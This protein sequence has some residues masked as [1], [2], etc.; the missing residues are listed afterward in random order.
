MTLPKSTLPMAILFKDLKDRVRRLMGLSVLS[1]ELLPEAATEDEQET[2]I[3]EDEKKAAEDLVQSKTAFLRGLL[4][5]LGLLQYVDAFLNY[6]MDNEVMVQEYLTQENLVDMK[7]NPT[8]GAAILRHVFPKGEQRWESP[9]SRVET[10]RTCSV[11]PVTGLIYPSEIFP[12][13]SSFKDPLA[14]GRFSN[15]Y[16]ARHQLS[17]VA[18]KLFKGKEAVT[19]LEQEYNILAQLSDPHVPRLMGYIDCIEVVDE[20]RYGYYALVTEYAE[21]GSLFRVLHEEKEEKQ[22]DWVKALGI[23][24]CVA[25]GL[26]Y[27]HSKYIVHANVNSHNVLVRHDW[28]AMLTDF[29]SARR[30]ASSADV[31]AYVRLDSTRQMTPEL[32]QERFVVLAYLDIESFGVVLQ[33]ILTQKVPFYEMT[34]TDM[35]AR[36]QPQETPTIPE[37]VCPGGYV[38]LMKACWNRDPCQVPSWATIIEDLTAIYQR[39]QQPH[40]MYE[41]FPLPL[42]TSV[43]KSMVVKGSEPIPTEDLMETEQCKRKFLESVLGPLDLLKHTDAFMAAGRNTIPKLGGMNDKH[44]AEMKIPQEDCQVIRNALWPDSIFAY[45]YLEGL[46]RA[47]VLQEVTV[48]PRGIL[49]IS[50]LGDLPPTDLE[51]GKISDICIA[52]NELGEGTSSSVYHA[53]Y[54]GARVVLKTYKCL[55]VNDMIGEKELCREIKVLSKLSHPN[56]VKLIGFIHRREACHLVLEC[57]TR[58][59]LAHLL[60]GESKRDWNKYLSIALC[61]AKGGKYMH[62]QGIVHRDLKAS[63]ILIREDWSA[64]ITDFGT[65]IE[66]ASDVWTSPCKLEGGVGSIRW[67]APEVYAGKK[68]VVYLLDIYSFGMILCE[69]ATRK[70]PFSHLS[71]N[72]LLRFKKTLGDEE[73]ELVIPED[74]YPDG[75]VSLIKACVA[76]D[77]S[78][79]PSWEE[80]IQ[81][82]EQ[83]RGQGALQGALPLEPP[84]TSKGYRWVDPKCK[85]VLV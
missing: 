12:K 52:A 42:H 73:K 27:M 24:L 83:M 78:Q 64:C 26:A 15:V 23:A 76:V 14:V 39:V 72:A 85:Y 66:V 65:C 79:R 6:G 81:R 41:I 31:L 40:W 56:I 63:N 53:K 48:V 62:S 2:E 61:V 58:N 84:K 49:R 60:A 47:T 68:G 8:H 22:L 37:S 32:W 19:A 5:P 70:M 43:P 35:D 30:V 69:I 25:K 21:R 57:A 28:S 13:I 9:P 1:T 34:D 45:T 36:G 77:P 4:G 50:T 67:I 71:D 75:L 46:E 3:T 82:L 55:G 18:I 7:V 74:D 20:I 38:D 51:S 54:K 80:I 59:S 10:R 44:L 33:E 16:Q 11:L 17:I 29:G